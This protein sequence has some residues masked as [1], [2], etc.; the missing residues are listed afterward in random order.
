[1]PAQDTIQTPPDTGLSWPSGWTA[2]IRGPHYRL[3]VAGG[4]A[5]ALL[6]VVLALVHPAD[7]L[8]LLVVAVGVFGYALLPA[9]Y[10]PVRVELGEVPGRPPHRGAQFPLR[11][12]SP[13]GVLRRRPTI[14][15]TPTAVIAD[16]GRTLVIPWSQIT[17]I[18][19]V[20]A[21]NRRSGWPLPRSRQNWLA[22][23]VA[24]AEASDDA[25][26]RLVH[27]F[28]TGLGADTAAGFTVTSLLTDPV[29]LFHTLHYY[30]ENPQARPEL[31]G[32]DGLDRIREERVDVLDQ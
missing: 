18:Q 1:M 10:Y 21:A 22:I 28:G 12:T 15:L 14:T 13:L 25:R 19:A 23:T 29:V 6:A 24:H 32:Q 11:I 26:A 4:V 31:A 5:C 2:R 3:A 30:L 9:P 7:G 27:R 16:Q 17:D 20:D 8:V